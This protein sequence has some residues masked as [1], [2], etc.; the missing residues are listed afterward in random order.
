MSSPLRL[1]CARDPVGEMRG[2]VIAN[3]AP[4]RTHRRGVRLGA[5]VSVLVDP[6]IRLQT[7]IDARGRPEVGTTSGE[8]VCSR[9]RGRRPIRCRRHTIAWRV[10]QVLAAWAD[11]STAGLRSNRGT[12]PDLMDFEIPGDRAGGTRAWLLDAQDR[13]I[14]AVGSLDDDAVIRTGAGALGRVDSRPTRMVTMMLT[15]HVHHLAEIGTL[16]DGLH[17]EAT[18]SASATPDVELIGS[19]PPRLVDGA[20]DTAGAT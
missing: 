3:R 19:R 16:R 1:R 15:E 4:R 12:R 20:G 13:F 7:E 18:R 2:T 17:D 8:F 9:T 6:S 14:D 10:I 11:Q 5:G